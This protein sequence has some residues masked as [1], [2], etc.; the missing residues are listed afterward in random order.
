MSYKLN[1]INTLNINQIE[2]NPDLSLGV[3]TKMKKLEEFIRRCGNVNPIVVSKNDN[4][5]MYKIIIG[6]NTFE[7]AEKLGIKQLHSVILDNEDPDFLKL[8]SLQWSIIDNNIGSISQGLLID[9][10]INEHEFSIT[11]L[12][13]MLKKSKSWLSKRWSLSKN[14]TED[15]KRLVSSRDLS[16]RTAEEIAKLPIE[17]QNKFGRQVLKNSMSKETVR[18][19]VKL[20]NDPDTTEITK[21]KIL[22]SPEELSLMEPMK[23][24]RKK[25]LSTEE[26]FKIALNN[27]SKSIKQVS[28]FL[29]NIDINVLHSF[30]DYIIILNKNF[31]LL[32][33][34]ITSRSQV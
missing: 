3:D 26:R 22:E 8:M 1:K 12:S 30:E 14:L 6:Q 23:N 17:A 10:L 2:K 9:Q 13:E 19:L 15:M 20:Y 25:S 24:R 28:I 27:I 5:C 33:N 11:K 7:I 32:I 4:N 16:P 18:M 31:N 29:N 34:D 21:N